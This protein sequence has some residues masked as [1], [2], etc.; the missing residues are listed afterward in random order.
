MGM[1]AAENGPLILASSSPRRKSLLAEAGYEFIVMQP[2][3][4][5]EDAI[6]QGEEPAELV[7]RLALQKARDVAKRCEAGIIIGC[8]TVA[9]CAGEILGKPIDRADARRMLA[10]LRGQEH[11]V[12]SGLCLW[13]RP[14]NT[15][16]VEL[17]IT[18][19]V[20]DPITDAELENYLNSD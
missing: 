16:R 14:D 20:M 5:A 18:R 7:Q 19:L 1:K 2:D 15:H 17:E 11:R 9:K 8:D 6:A 12:Y 13:R 4:G 3:D 10:L